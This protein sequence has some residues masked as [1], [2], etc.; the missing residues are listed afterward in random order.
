MQKAIKQ[1]TQ[2]KQTVDILKRIAKRVEEATI[3][4][5]DI[6]FD[7]KSVKLRLGNVEHNTKIMKVDIEKI[8]N[9]LEVVKDTMGTMR[10]DIKE[11]K[12]EV[13]GLTETTG[14]ILKK[15]VT[16]DEHSALSQRVASLEQS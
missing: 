13:E 11:I 8:K 10:Q 4:I 5:H 3:D 9:E 1:K 16:Q 7:L 12:R 6:R 15:A 2:E 14:F